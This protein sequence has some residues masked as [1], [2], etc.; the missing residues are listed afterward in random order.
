MFEHEIL[1]LDRLSEYSRDLCR[2]KEISAHSEVPYDIIADKMN[3]ADIVQLEWWNHPLIHLFLHSVPF[4]K[5]RLLIFSH[6]SG[7]S[8]PAVFTRDIIELADVFCLSTPYS[9]EHPLIQTVN[10][11]KI[12][13]IFIAG[14][15]VD[16]VARV[17]PKAH[18]GFNVGYIGTLDFCKMHPD[19]ISMS[20]GADISDVHFI[21]CGDGDSQQQLLE[22][23]AERNVASR[24]SFNG[25]VKD[26]GSVFETMDVFGYPL[27]PRHYGTGEQALLEAMGAGV[28]PVVF[29]NGCER[30]IVHHEETGLIVESPKEY[31]RA[32]EYLYNNPDV[33]FRLGANA[34]QYA[35]KHFTLA[36][37]V[38]KLH[39]V[40]DELMGQPKHERKA[41]L[42][43]VALGEAEPTG[44]ELFLSSQGDSAG[45]FAVS[46]HSHDDAALMVADMAI[47]R[48]TPEMTTPTKGSVIHYARTFPGDPVLDYWRGLIAQGK[49]DHE[50]AVRFFTQS[51]ETGRD[52]W[53]VH[54][55][56]SLSLREMGK[57]DDARLRV[58]RVLEDRPSFGPARQA[59]SELSPQP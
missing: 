51:C 18:P 40:Y 2:E 36:S 52:D 26:I 34:R 43:S 42:C 31:T 12:R 1:C 22:E 9:E 25:F 5:T 3:D 45:D 13:T 23:V 35:L 11:D 30:S 19:F 7:F 33:R 32:I 49:G 20:A 24:F 39:A 10:R 27:N 21:L 46:A 41:P 54:W 38:S 56:M 55:F 50:D 44:H 8:P 57:G 28:T 14:G 17:S 4:P 48:S 47:A 15:T 29:A 59:L 37:T 58:Q 16:R 6:I 53:R